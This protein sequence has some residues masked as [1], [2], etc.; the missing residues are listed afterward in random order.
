F[1]ADEI[2]L[3][4]VDKFSQPDFRGGVLLCVDQCFLAGRVIDFDQDEPCFDAGDIESEH[5]CGMNIKEAA[6]G[7]Q[8]VPDL[9]GVIPRHPDFKAKVTGVPSAGNIDGHAGDFAAS[10]TK[11][12]QVVDLGVTDAFEQATGR[13]ALQS[14]CRDLFGNVVDLDV[15]PDGV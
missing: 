4:Q 10:H 13:R 14:Q 1:P 5:P 12:L 8:F 15:E 9:D 7:H 2:L 3:F 6:L 11:V